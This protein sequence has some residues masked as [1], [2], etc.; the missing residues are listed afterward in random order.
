MKTFFAA[1]LSILLFCGSCAGQTSDGSTS[2]KSGTTQSRV[3]AVAQARS[4]DEIVREQIR[5]HWIVN[6]G[7][8][9]L[10]AMV[11][12]IA[13]EMNPDG[14]VQS[15]KIN[16]STDNG[17]PKWPLAAQRCL[18]AVMKSS[19]LQMPTDEPYEAWRRLTLRFTGKELPG[20]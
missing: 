14:S 7:M 13:V 12:E 11:V 2:A 20:S 17:N 18:R 16:P 10:E 6:I 8:D 4:G 9:G 5:G 15:A 19:P 1:L 3:Q